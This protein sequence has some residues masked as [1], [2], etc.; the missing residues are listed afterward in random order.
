MFRNEEEF[1]SAPVHG[2]VGSEG[3]SLLLGTTLHTGIAGSFCFSAVPFH[4]VG[5][6]SMHTSK[7]PAQKIHILTAMRH[8]GF[9]HGATCVPSW[10]HHHTSP[11]NCYACSYYP[12]CFLNGIITFQT[13]PF[14]T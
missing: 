12:L 10:C 13:G 2:A 14:S 4:E 3:Y 6:W 5:S 11:F 8:R 1:C 7:M 9:E